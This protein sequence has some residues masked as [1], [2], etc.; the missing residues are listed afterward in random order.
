LLEKS[1]KRRH[2]PFDNESWG[3]LG[4]M[5]KELSEFTE[6]TEYIEKKTEESKIESMPEAG[7]SLLAVMVSDT[8]KFYEQLVHTN[9]EGNLY[10][11]TPILIHIQPDIFVA[12]LEKISPENKRTVGYAL[13]ERYKYDLFLDKIHEEISW[14]KQVRSILSEKQQLLRGKVS[15]Y[16]IKIIYNNIDN[17][18][19]ALDEYQ[20]RLTK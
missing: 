20:N 2:T 3:G 11:E 14:L 17:S 6:L 1:K 7:K 9:S 10:Y 18:I 12:E 8:N 5:G 15:G 13:A 4:F 16:L 19:T